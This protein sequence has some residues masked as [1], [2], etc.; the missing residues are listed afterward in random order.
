[1]KRKP[2]VLGV[3][4]APFCLFERERAG[5]RF[6]PLVGVLLKGFQLVCVTYDRVEI[7]G[8][9]ATEAIVRLVGKTRHEPEI[10]V[11]MTDGV[12][13]G[14]FNVVDLEEV[15][16]RTGKKVVSVS[17]VDPDFDAIKSALQ[18]HFK[19]WEARWAVVQKSRPLLSYASNPDVSPKKVHAKAVGLEENELRALLRR[20]SKYGA[21]PEPVRVAHVVASGLR[22]LDAAWL[23]SLEK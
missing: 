15:A 21:L 9:D 20:V 12:T 16:A 18:K 8:T 5:P 23:E 14:G 11:V 6:V 4:D 7:D 1:M 22:Y 19:D 2:I 17:L 10:Q 3:D 13:F